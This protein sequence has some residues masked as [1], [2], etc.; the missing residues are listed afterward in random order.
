MRQR[1]F[2]L[3]YLVGAV[4]IA[5]GSN[6]QSRYVLQAFGDVNLGRSVGQELLKGHIAFPFE[7]VEAAFRTADAVFVNLESVLSDQGGE[8]QNPKDVF[9]F[10]GPPQGAASL[11]RAHISIVSTA[12]NHAY[13]YGLKGL[14]QTIEYLQREDIAFVG[15]STEPQSIF[16]PLLLPSKEIRIA[17]LAYTEFVNARGSWKNRISVFD[18]QRAKSEI[19][20]ARNV[21]DIVVASYHG[22]TE[23]TDEPSKFTLAQLRYLADAGADIVLGHHPHV[24][25]GIEGRGGRLIFYSLGN[26]VFYQPQHVWTQTGMGVEFVFQKADGR[27]RLEAARIIPVHASKQPSFTVS[28]ADQN[29]LFERLQRLSNVTLERQES[30]IR[31]LLPANR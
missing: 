13:D 3:A 30:S 10:C 2:T 19:D 23:Y 9:V 22:G 28:E 18:K 26:L 25:Q 5:Q 27:T 24:P 12:N 11:K 8:T 20:S 17:L 1:A 6:A 7:N 21:A 31:I 14:R 29:A 16:K 4:I 15:T